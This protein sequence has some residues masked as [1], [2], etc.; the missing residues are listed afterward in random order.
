MAATSGCSRVV[1]VA[2]ASSL[3]SQSRELSAVAMKPSRLV[4]V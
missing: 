2:V 4:A 1:A 3:K